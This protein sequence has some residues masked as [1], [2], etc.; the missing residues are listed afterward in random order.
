MI[1][2]HRLSFFLLVALILIGAACTSKLVSNEPESA[3]TED[4]A[5]ES[6]TSDD[7]QTPKKEE[8]GPAQRE[9]RDLAERMFG[10]IQ[11]S[12]E[13][14]EAAPFEVYQASRRWLEQELALGP[15]AAQRVVFQQAHL[16]R[17]RDMA[18]YA[19]WRT[20][21]VEFYV[22]DAELALDK[23]QPDPAFVPTIVA[24]RAL[25]GDWEVVSAEEDGAAVKKPDLKSL[26]ILGRRAEFVFRLGAARALITLD[27]TI[28]PRLFDVF[29]LSESYAFGG[30][31]IYKLDGDRLTIC[32]SASA[33]RPKTFAT[34]AGDDTRL[35]VLKRDKPEAK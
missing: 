20:S 29:S 7:T 16:D 33:D 18:N 4:T 15:T 35:Y 32:W 21:E 23:L 2:S 28:D 8:A 9:L 11:T 5:K 1:R 30:H 26:T 22:A 34:H 10:E 27:P 17:M 31:G 25:E 14:S 19:L 6:Q 12:Y 13:S 3:K 24:R